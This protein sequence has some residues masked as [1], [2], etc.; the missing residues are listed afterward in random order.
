VWGW[1]GVALD[2]AGNVLTGV[3]N[4]D[5]GLSHGTISAPFVTAPQEYSGYGETLLELSS[6]ISSVVAS[7][8]PIPVNIYSGSVNDLDVQG[9][10]LVVRPNGAGCGAMVAPQGKSGEFSVYNESS[11]GAGLAAQYQLSPVADQLG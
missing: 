4:A 2:S 8:H 5:N 1:G 3:G 9:T 7:N 11:L 6:N 10:P